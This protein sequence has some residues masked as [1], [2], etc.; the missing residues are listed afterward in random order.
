VLLD[1]GLDLPAFAERPDIAQDGA[2][3]LKKLPSLARIAVSAAG[4]NA[5]SARVPD[6]SPLKSDFSSNVPAPW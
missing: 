3:L 2:T 1:V 5:V 4:Q 6:S